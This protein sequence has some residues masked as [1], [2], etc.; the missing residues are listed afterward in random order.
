M[1]KNKTKKLNLTKI[2]LLVFKIILFGI[3][4]MALL[5]SIYNYFNQDKI[6]NYQFQEKIFSNN[7]TL[8][9]GIERIESRQIKQINFLES[10]LNPRYTFLI[11]TNDKLGGYTINF[12]RGM[13]Q[14]I[15]ISK[16]ESFTLDETKTFEERLKEIEENTLNTLK[17][18]ENVESIKF[19]GEK[20]TK[21]YR[22]IGGLDVVQQYF[23]GIYPEEENRKL[24]GWKIFD[25]VNLKVNTTP[26]NY[27]EKQKPELKI[28]ILLGSKIK[29]FY[30][31][32]EAI[33]VLEDSDYPNCIYFIMQFDNG[34]L[35]KGNPRQDSY[36]KALRVVK[37]DR[38]YIEIPPK[39][40]GTF[41]FE[42]IK[43]KL[44]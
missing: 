27:I 25:Y 3:M 39:A 19:E 35:T 23:E 21:S 14:E 40:D 33:S 31:Q 29:K 17:I 42:S 11:K 43:D 2:S 8:K 4:V 20:Y 26:Y 18:A 36:L 24:K 9:L 34:F 1:K 32:P 28:D 15:Y 41:D 30:D 38:S 10:Y 13:L 7:P 16:L 6:A 37:K 44:K 5:S 12:K 22:Q